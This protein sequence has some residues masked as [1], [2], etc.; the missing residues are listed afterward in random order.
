MFAK[1][2]TPEPINLEQSNSQTP[3]PVYDQVAEPSHNFSEELS[4]TSNDSTLDRGK[5][6]PF[7]S[8]PSRVQLTWPDFEELLT[9]P[10]TEPTEVIAQLNSTLVNRRCYYQGYWP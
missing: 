8:Q 1:R 10:D 6:L 2:P 3:L 7:P 4:Q 5:V 9:T